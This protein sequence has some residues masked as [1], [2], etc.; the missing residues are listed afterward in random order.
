MRLRASSVLVVVTL[1]I[2]CGGACT[3]STPVSPTG[4]PQMSGV[5]RNYASSV[6]TT[7]TTT[8][9]G[10]NPT[11]A[12]QNITTSYNTATNQFSATGTGTYSNGIC[13]RSISWSMTYGSVADFVDEVSVIPPKTRWASQSGTVTDSGPGRC[14]NSTFAATTTNSYDS[15]GRLV[16]G[17]STGGL[18]FP[19]MTAIPGGT[20]VY[21]AWDVLG[22]PAAYRIAGPPPV[23]G[24]IS[25]DDSSRTRSTT[26]NLGG[27]STTTAVDA[28][29]SDGNPVRSQR[30][31]RIPP[32]P[33][34]GGSGVAETADTTFV[35]HA[36]R[37]VCR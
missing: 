4:P 26:V 34:R 29:D 17:V 6:T 21:T 33:L 5:C 32:P 1:L 15:Q 30:V 16:S 18:S 13:G 25:Y 35:I 27:I 20:A 28:I 10:Q 2:G 23:S 22:R 37:R 3:S 12:T 19:N 11:V 7:I 36:T 14:G 8:F 9:P 31:V 24:S